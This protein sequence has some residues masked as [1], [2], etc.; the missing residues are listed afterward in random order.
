MVKI[1][2]TGY[3]FL[4]SGILDENQIEKCI[5]DSVAYLSENHGLDFS[6]LDYVINVVKN[7]EGKK[8]GHTYVWVNDDKLF[9]ALIGKNFDGT[10]SFEEVLDEDWEEPEESYDDAIEAADGDWRGGEGGGENQTA[11]RPK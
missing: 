7:R 11:G 6:K 4:Q 9:Y 3:L 2:E 1:S 5:K 10:E 8:F